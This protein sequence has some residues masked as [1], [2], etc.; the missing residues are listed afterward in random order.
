MMMDP[1]SI[2]RFLSACDAAVP[3]AALI[4][5]VS[6]VRR[7]ITSPEWLAWKK[8]GLRW[9]R[10]AK[11]S[12]RTSDTTRSPSQLTEKKRVALAVAKTAPMASITA[13]YWSISSG[14]SLKK[15]RSIM[16]RTPI[17][18]ASIAAADASSAT[19]ASATIGL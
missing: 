3:A 2:T 16:R 8:A 13:K 5:V 1:I 6:A 19:K 17:G 4:W 14:L 7:D 11:T 18:K 10:C 15:P 12:R 9:A